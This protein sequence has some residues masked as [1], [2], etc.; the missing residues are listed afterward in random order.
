[1]DNNFSNIKE[2]IL[3]LSKNK[4]FSFEKFFDEI[5]M[6]YGNFKGQNKKRPINSDAIVNI[7]TLI[8]DVNPTWLL[9][10]K[11]EMFKSEVKNETQPANNVLLEQEN[12]FLKEKNAL[13]EENKAL[14]QE[15]VAKLEA[16]VQALKSSSQSM[17]AIQ[18]S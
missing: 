12:A 11:G 10:G 6:S 8:P 7:L 4:G 9:T 18:P 15:K 17:R 2:R 14:L 3:Q 16:E 1:M 5:G 13:L